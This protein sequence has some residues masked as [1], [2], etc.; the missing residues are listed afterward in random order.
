MFFDVSSELVSSFAMPPAELHETMQD[1]KRVYTLLQENG[2][3]KA[4]GQYLWEKLVEREQ[5]SVSLHCL[6]IVFSSLAFHFFPEQYCNLEHTC[7]L[8]F[9]IC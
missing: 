8:Q 9:I 4:L 7:S 3:N 6:V 2:L 1:F 5:Y